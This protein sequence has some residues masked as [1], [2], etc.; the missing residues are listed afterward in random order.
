MGSLPSLRE[1]LKSFFRTEIRD[2][3][4][5][6]IIHAFRK[7]WA[8][9]IDLSSIE[10]KH[11]PNTPTLLAQ[12]IAS[13]VNSADIDTFT[14][15]GWGIFLIYPRGKAYLPPWNLGIKTIDIYVLHFPREIPIEKFTQ[16][17]QQR[18]QIKTLHVRRETFKA[19]AKTNT[20]KIIVR[21]DA[22]DAPRVPEFF[23]IGGLLVQ[24]WFYGCI[25]IRPCS[26]CQQTGHDRWKCTKQN[27]ETL[28][29]KQQTPQST[30]HNNHTASRNKETTHK[31]YAESANSH[32]SL[33]VTR[34]L[35][36]REIDHEMSNTNI[37][38]STENED[39]EW[40]YPKRKKEKRKTFQYPQLLL[41][42]YTLT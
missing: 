27:H 9:A 35:F 37:R 14:H 38:Q 30:N 1:N 18:L 19:M 7:Q 6:R 17:F 4:E 41:N 15:S 16:G 3:E 22:R 24:S 12:I 10:A 29:T 40:I 13:G 25:H 32:S 23:K 11:R 31:S 2:S 42:N 36:G 5:G 34:N 21:I 39:E 26:S 33:P 20:G 8:Q 28:T